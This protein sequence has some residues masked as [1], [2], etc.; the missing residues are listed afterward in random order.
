M[1]LLEERDRMKLVGVNFHLG[2]IVNTHMTNF[3]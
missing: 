3:F 2:V 1:L